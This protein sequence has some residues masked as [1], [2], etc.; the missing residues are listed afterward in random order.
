VT[1][2]EAT[3]TETTGDPTSPP[4]ASTTEE[5][6]FETYV[7]AGYGFS[8]RYRPEWQLMEG[9]NYV[10]LSQ[11]STTLVIGYRHGTEDPNICCRQRLPKGELVEVGTVACGE[12]DVDRS[13]LTCEGKTKAVVYG[14]S[15]EISLG[16]L[17]FL[18]YLEDFRADYD[19]A[20]IPED[21]QR[22]VDRVISSLETF[23]P[24]VE[25]AT[26]AQVQ[27]TRT[28]TAPPEPT[29]EP[30]A[31]PPTVTPSPSPPPAIAHVQTDGANVRSGPG[32]EYALEGTLD[33]GEQVEIVGRY[34]DWW[35]ITYGASESHAGHL[36]WVYD[37]VVTAQDADRVPQV[38]SAPT[39]VPSSPAVIPTAAPTSEI[40][41]ARWIDVNLTEQRLTAYEDGAPVRSTLISTGLSRT[42]TVQGQFRIW[43]KLRYDDM[44]GEDYY[45]EDVPHVMYF[46]QGYGLHAAPWHNNFGH[47]MSHGCVNLPVPEAEWLFNFADVGTLVNVHE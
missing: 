38:A 45:L 19:A 14:G 27:A 20:E 32:T 11:G 28:A 37:G 29:V 25:F 5:P 34:G 16:E 22:Q 31:V 46:Y 40:E 43:I 18:F 12:E 33:G 17:R 42:P 10:S 8:F 36:A 35:Q 44:E 13:L 47:R 41:E 21:V 3:P 1:T 23:A 2:P 6:R 9:R 4:A 15:E 30:T 7:N 24:T 26:P 39:P